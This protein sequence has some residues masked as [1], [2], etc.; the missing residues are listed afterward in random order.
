M[1]TD[2]KLTTIG[3]ILLVVTIGLNYYHESGFNY[4]YITGIAMVVV[5]MTS[6]VK[7]NVESF[8]NKKK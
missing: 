3:V 5:F 4:A 6:F 1:K 2:K 8:R 7:F